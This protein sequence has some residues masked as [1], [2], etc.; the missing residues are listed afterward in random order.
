MWG[1]RGRVGHQR[2]EWD[3]RGQAGASQRWLGIKGYTESFVNY[4]TAAKTEV[5]TLVRA[6]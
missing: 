5:E 2:A 6:L 1:I 4:W 3:I